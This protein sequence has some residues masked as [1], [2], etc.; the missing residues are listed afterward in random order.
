MSDN[1]GPNQTRVLDL[2][3]RSFESVV[4]QRKKPPLSCEVNLTGSLASSH[5]QDLS[6][7]MAPSGWDVVGS[8]RENT[9]INSCSCGDV[10]TSSTLSAN[11]FKLV[12][13][14]QGALTRGLVALVNG[15]ELHV[16]GTNSG[17]ENNLI[18]LPVPPS[19]TYRVDFVF[20]EVWRKLVSPTDTVYAYGNVLYGGTNPSNDLIDPAINIE[21]TKRI[22]TQYRIRVVAGV[23][24]INN[25]E[26]FDPNQVFVQGPLAAPITYCNQAYFVPVSGDM[27]LWRAGDGSSATQETLG[28]V[29]G[30][31]YAIPMFAIGRRNTSSYS[32]STFSNGAGRTL[33]DY[34]AGLSS[35]RPDGKYSDW[36]VPEDILDLRHLIATSM[37]TKKLATSAFQRLI[38][39]QYR[40]KMEASFKGEDYV[41][42][43]LVQADSIGSVS[44]ADQIGGTGTTPDGIRR[45]FSN[46]GTTQNLIYKVFT[47]NDKKTGTQGTDWLNT[48][49]VEV[50]CASP[51]YPSGTR[52]TSF[53]EV[54]PYNIL[55]YDNTQPGGLRADQVTIPTFSLPLDSVTITIGGSLLQGTPNSFFVC[56]TISIPA[57]ANGFTYL[58]DKV[59]EFREV[60]GVTASSFP[61]AAQGN[62]LRIH[63]GPDSSTVVGSSYNVLSNRGA[64]L[65]EPYDFGHQMIYHVDGGGI[66]RSSI[67]FSRVLGKLVSGGSDGYN[68]LGIASILV[69]GVLTTPSSISRTATDYIVNFLPS[70]LGNDIQFNLYTATKFFATSK[71]GRGV[72]E[73]YEMKEYTPTSIVDTTAYIDV[74]VSPNLQQG[75]AM[76]SNAWS[77][78]TG[79]VYV[80][81]T[82]QMTLT[83]NNTLPTSE[84]WGVTPPESGSHLNIIFSSPPVGTI[85]VPLLTRSAI[86]ASE[87]YAIF[88]NRTPYQG[89]LDSSATGVV[90]GEGNALTTTAGSG[91]ITDYIIDSDTSAFL[92][93]LDIV[94]DGTS[95]TSVG[96]Y[97]YGNVHTGDI[98]SFVDS[99]IPAIT[100]DYVISDVVSNTSLIVSEAVNLGS[101]T[102]YTIT[103]PDVPS[104]AGANTIDRL[105]IYTSACDSSGKSE[106]LWSDYNH[107]TPML[108]TR[109]IERTQDILDLPVNMINVGENTT[110][111]DG[112]GR[113]RVS[114]P[115][116]YG[117]LGQNNLGLFFETLAYYGTGE[118]Q[119][120]Y[121]SYL[122][123]K[124][125]TRDGTNFGQVPYLMVVGSE[126]GSSV[127]VGAEGYTRKLNPASNL[128]TVDLFELPGRPLTVRERS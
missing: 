68:I 90:V 99:S 62:D 45:I 50:S 76:T 102:A 98:I 2:T 87:K 124:N 64:P 91:A 125:V 115:A 57:G 70:I 84:N 32:P 39:G 40:S 55:I 7:F 49:T 16:Q 93:P 24:I 59:L 33:A 48:D 105:P 29:D 22:Q 75:I 67:T 110:A 65:N 56:Y 117:P 23:D 38:K 42:S 121:Q 25:P 6:K 101:L 58:P 107:P 77:D 10:F 128:D 5:A 118:Y 127:G 19:I 9:A 111:L 20:L 21:T 14:E 109:I 44:W 83:N 100:K 52:I 74:G 46:A 82:Q 123:N 31:T 30:Y 3:N 37:D 41:N 112:R 51:I 97:W 28:T 53:V 66:L 106:D 86:G 120:T 11:S 27:G 1:L 60:T 12:A 63:A 114:M 122:F 88:Y 85:E 104:F 95:I 71:Q 108:E 8:I 4:Y 15:W 96:T 92:D 26:G 69:D 119:K 18:T 79:Y 72:I 89:L 126:T 13:T 73:T 34:L 61:I 54:G 116:E 78:G 35:D 113:S 103:R 36:I 94:V 17:D 80:N 43:V 47:V 81:G